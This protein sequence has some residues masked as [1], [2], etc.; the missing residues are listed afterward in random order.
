MANRSYCF[1]LFHGSGNDSDRDQI[2]LASDGLTLESFGPDVR[3]IIYQKEK[4]PDTGRLHYQGY[5]ELTKPMRITALAKRPI[6]KTAH[7]EPRRG[8]REEARD[9]CRKEESRVAGPFEFGKWRSGGQGA[10]TDW[11]SIKESVKS[12]ASDADIAE[13]NPGEF[14]RNYRGIRELRLALRPKRVEKTSVFVFYG[15]P[16]VGKTTMAAQ[17]YPG[18]YWKPPNSKWFDG[19]Q[20]EETVV[21]DD[22]DGSWLPISTLKRLMDA[23][24]LMVETKGGM[25]QFLAKQLVI[26]TNDLPENWYPGVYATYPD[27]ILAIVRRIDE[28]TE[29][30]SYGVTR[31]KYPNTETGLLDSEEEEINV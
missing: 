25:V 29:V 22:F 11:D 8:T 31:S 27:Q 4:C 18:A 17:L 9:Y 19:Y 24:P 13:S 26:T 12:G 16:N 20:G 2:T 7:F 28:F 15:R 30:L 21:F 10:R 6:F 1:T 5:I 3:Y 14:I 23:Q